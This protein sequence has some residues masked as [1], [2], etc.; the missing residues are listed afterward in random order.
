MGRDKLSNSKQREPIEYIRRDIPS[1]EAPQYPGERYEAMVPDTLDLQERATLAVN[2]LTGPTDPEADYE[3]Y[4]RAFF[5]YNP[6]MMQHDGNDHVQVKFLEALPL[7]RLICGKEMRR[8]VDQRWMAVL[9]HM[10]GPDGSL[11]YP[12]KGRPWCH[13]KT[14]GGPP[15]DEHYMRPY[16]DGRLLGAIAIYYLLTGDELWVETGQ[17]VAGA[18]QSRAVDRGEYAY[19]PAI[20][21]DW[22]AEV[23]SSAPIPNAI[24]CSCAGWVLQG[25][26]QFY[27]FT[28]YEPARDLAT[29]LAYGLKDHTGCFDEE[30]R[31]SGFSHF[32]HH[33]LPLLAVADHGMAISDPELLA[34][35]RQGY[36]FAKSQGEPLLGYFPEA[37]SDGYETSETCE[38][39]D[40]I[41]LA[42]KL[43][44]AGVGDYW[45]DIDRWTRNQFAEAQM[46]RSDWVDRMM[47]GRPY[48]V[49]DPT[50][51]TTDRVAER[52]IGSF[53]GW[54]S[55][56]DWY[57][58]H[59]AGGSAIMHC[60]TGNGTRT[61]YYVWENILS[62]AGDRL[63]VN[64]LLNRASP[65][66]D[67]DSHIPY[68][69]QV[70]VS[71]KEPL[72]L[73]LRIPEWV[74]QHEV[75]CTVGGLGRSLSWEGRYACVGALK[76]GHVASLTFPI[77][78]RTVQVNV[79][80]RPYTLV[81][82]GNDV[83]LID[84]PG[85][86]CPLY[87]RSHYRNNDTR[88]R[89]IQRFVSDREIAW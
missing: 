87:Q 3:I 63:R 12:V 40:M 64:L 26:S 21:Y 39:A 1:F 65:W 7:M 45:D 8:E 17:K 30:G 86:C 85:R 11:Y 66:A 55:A 47:E 19:F 50:Y 61:I 23:D 4:W 67:I 83:V 28:G 60:C 31:F 69:G 27:R 54:P 15:E 33:S 24:T 6:P 13:I 9:L 74:K 34:F 10:Q 89:K 70:D 20:R 44:L 80:K 22:G 49:V 18:L 53:A 2:G 72:N 35:A 59:H 25:L 51:Q 37:L 38:V 5:S 84:P 81:V 48:S 41:G 88:W 82:R 77:S 79:Q 57:D 73:Y 56:N 76:P 58:S 71:V 62:H 75:A 46:L 36:E 42:I 52:N 32:H 78:E 16:D 68:A 43:T 14:F 29:K